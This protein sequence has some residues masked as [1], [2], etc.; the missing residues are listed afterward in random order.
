MNFGPKRDL[1]SFFIFSCHFFVFVFL[2]PLPFVLFSVMSTGDKRKEEE[3]N[4]ERIKKR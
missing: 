3:K 1:T 2:L 4:A